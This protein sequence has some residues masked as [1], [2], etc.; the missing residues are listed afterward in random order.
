MNGFRLAVVGAAPTADAFVR[1][2][3]GAYILFLR[4]LPLPDIRTR[5]SGRVRIRDRP[6]NSIF[7]FAMRFTSL[8]WFHN[9]IGYK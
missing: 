7:D 2:D 9:T 5:T 3:P 1:V 8:R 4:I 6:H